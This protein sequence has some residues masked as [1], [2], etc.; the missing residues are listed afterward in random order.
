MADIKTIK[1][2]DYDPRI[3]SEDTGERYTPDCSDLSFLAGAAGSNDMGYRGGDFGPFG[4][5]EPADAWRTR[6]ERKERLR[7]HTVDQ[8]MSTFAF[9]KDKSRG[10]TGQ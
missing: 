3:L 2:S 6:Y 1:R 5:A 7:R 10:L 8:G 9:P 4:L